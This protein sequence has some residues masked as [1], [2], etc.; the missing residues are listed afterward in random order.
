MLCAAILLDG[1]TCLLSCRTNDSGLSAR[2][3]EARDW[4]SAWRVSTNTVCTSPCLRIG[5]HLYN[6]LCHLLGSPWNL[7]IMRLIMERG[8]RKVQRVAILQS[9]R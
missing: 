6:T 3:Q 1:L 9:C 7:D 8:E 4:I 2:Q 5:V